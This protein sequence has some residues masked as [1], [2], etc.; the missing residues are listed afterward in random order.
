MAALDALMGCP[1][2]VFPS[3]AQYGWTGRGTETFLYRYRFDDPEVQ[4]A[5]REALPV[6]RLHRKIGQQEMVHFRILSE[7]G[8]VQ[9]SAFA[10]GTRVIANFGRDV[11]GGKRGIGHVVLEGVDSLL[12][13][14]WMI[15]E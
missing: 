11:V 8:Y 14:S 15:A 3:G 9:E 13:E 1:P 2:D 5:L 6:A 4:I 7:D 10:D 12:P